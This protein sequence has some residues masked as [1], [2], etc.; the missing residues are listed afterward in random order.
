MTADRVASGVA[1][2]PSLA[3]LDALAP[4][5][6]KL[7]LEAI[8][9]LCERL[10]RPERAVPSVLVAGTNG[11]GST[12]ATLSAIARAAGL[13]AGLY[14]S[15][16]LIRVT[17][18]IRID[19]DDV[20]DAELD[21]CAGAGLRGG[22]PRARDPRDLFR[23]AHGGRVRGVRRARASIWRSSR[24][25]SA[26]V[27][28]RRTRA[29]APLDR[30]LD[31]PRPRRGP[32]PDAPTHR[33]RE[34]RRLP[35]RAAGARAGRRPRGPRDAA[36]GRGRDRSRL[37]R[38][39]RGARGR[40]RVGVGRRDPIPA[41][42]AGEKRGL[43]DPAAGGAPGVEHGARRAGR[44][45]A[46]AGGAEARR[47]RPSPRRSCG[48]GGPGASSGSPARA[49]SVY[50]DG[51]HNPDGAETLARFLRDA[52][53]AGRVALVFG[54]MADKDIEGIARVL[55]AP[56]RRR[57]GSLRPPRRG[58]PAP[59]SCCAASARSLRPPSRR[60]ASRTRSAARSP[61]RATTL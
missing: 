61:P 34:G 50:L 14:T 44:G 2:L 4:R 17:E 21:G 7:G 24:S 27:S 5:G 45:A 53:L 1:P 40:G 28:T 30:D 58:P 41:A 42:H 13:R 35:R 46:V 8:D 20:S 23:G 52:G 22:R 59:T 33:A 26:A 43:H 15:P 25:G 18:R 36:G 38:R 51:C 57:S 39:R 56:R 49:R 47:T 11:K 54:A 31:R 55:C 60:R 10:G 19:D 6:M 48:C 9:A 16:H 3:R 12:A 29:G 32:R 37:A